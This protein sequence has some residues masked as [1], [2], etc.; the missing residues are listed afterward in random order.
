MIIRVFSFESK[1]LS[2]P[3]LQ[4]QPLI[5]EFKM[6]MDQH[7]FDLPVALLSS[8]AS[9][10]QAEALTYLD[11]AVCSHQ[12]RSSLLEAFAQCHIS[13]DRYGFCRNDSQR[14]IWLV[15]KKF[16]ISNFRI[17]DLD[18]GYFL[19]VENS[20]V[21]CSLFRS[22]LT[23]QSIISIQMLYSDEIAEVC[24]MLPIVKSL[25]CELSSYEPE[26]ADYLLQKLTSIT[27]K[28]AVSFTND[29]NI[30]SELVKLLSDRRFDHLLTQL[31]VGVDQI[32]K[33][34]EVVQFHETINTCS[35][36]NAFFCNL[37][38]LSW[39][40][41]SCQLLPKLVKASPALIDVKLSDIA[42][43]YYSNNGQQHNLL[44]ELVKIPL[45]KLSIVRNVSKG[46]EAHA[47]QL[48]QAFA[49]P[50]SV[51]AHS[52]HTLF[53]F[54][55]DANHIGWE[56]ICALK[57]LKNLTLQS[58]QISAQEL[59]LILNH[60]PVFDQLG[61]LKLYAVATS[62]L[63]DVLQNRD[64]KSLQ[65][66]LLDDE[67]L[68]EYDL[69]NLLPVQ[70]IVFKERTKEL[71]LDCFSKI[72]SV[73]KGELL[74][75]KVLD[76]FCSSSITPSSF[77]SSLVMFPYANLHFLTLKGLPIRSSN[78]YILR[79]ACSK[80]QSLILYG[81]GGFRR[82]ELF[83]N[84]IMTSFPI[85]WPVLKTVQLL[86]ARTDIDCLKMILRCPSIERVDIY[87]SSRCSSSSSEEDY[88]IEFDLWQEIKDQARRYGPRIVKV[89][90]RKPFYHDIATGDEQVVDFQAEGGDGN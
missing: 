89:L 29:S 12:S 4:G 73:Q 53:L 52:L 20:A 31:D 71:E 76:M 49:L 50:T 46:L 3:E 74:F 67:E 83:T 36:E 61:L 42:C 64:D 79:V 15:G 25:K 57:N 58:F 5:F 32:I 65:I 88:D 21:D 82:D 44:D 22:A 86:H 38:T 72:I 30:G 34:H 90:F 81:L 62:V 66:A 27:S 48:L 51:L 55:I 39:M 63:R 54:H 40:Q 41:A 13:Y 8:I 19:R 7:L 33:E 24:A 28:V 56:C 77:S 18:L 47:E 1:T 78:L 87:R 11:S 60:F 10:L 75:P 37:H 16:K 9:Y 69:N 80:L 35:F 84:F 45:Q 14:I 85:D 2:Q 59:K 26:S 6:L 70:N 17:D 43:C 68:L 23:S